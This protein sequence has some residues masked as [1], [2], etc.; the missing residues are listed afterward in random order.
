MV[1][2]IIGLYATSKNRSKIQW[3]AVIGGMLMQYIIALFVLRTKAG[4]D[5]FNFI[6]FLARKL[7][8][9]AKDGVAFLTN[10]EVSQLGM[11]FFTVLP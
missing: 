7:L 3:N 11:F 1:V 8:G 2:A 9:F 6:S 5:I 4:Y 10:A